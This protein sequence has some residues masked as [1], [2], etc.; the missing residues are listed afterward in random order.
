[1]TL[2]LERD[3]VARVYKT[4]NYI[5]NGAVHALS[6][7]VCLRSVRLCFGVRGIE[8]GSF[9]VESFDVKLGTTV[10]IESVWYAMAEGNLCALAH[11]DIFGHCGW[12]CALVY[13]C[14]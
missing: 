5:C 3:P 10:S 9:L 2:F 6:M 11:C 4:G 1:M 12:I 8:G 7:A 13:P 14:V